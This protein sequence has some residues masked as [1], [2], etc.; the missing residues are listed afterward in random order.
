MPD[1]QKYIPAIGTAGY[2]ELL[3]PFD[4]KVSTNERFTLKSVRTIS[5]YLASNE[6][7]FNDVYI[8]N[9]IDASYANDSKKDIEILGIQSERGAWVY[10]PVS[11][12]KCYPVVNGIPYRTMSIVVPLQPIALDIDL[13]GLLSQIND[14]VASY[15]GFIPVSKPVETSKVVLVDSDKHAALQIDRAILKSNSTP[16]AVIQKL[17][18]DI[19]VAVDK[20]HAL[21]DYIRTHP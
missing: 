16:Y 2:F 15:L 7:V 20:V 6:D 3:T 10:V 17:N 19:A 18:N 12:V 9:G 5:E 11:Y 1:S 4:V 21:E 14:V 8:K 13:T